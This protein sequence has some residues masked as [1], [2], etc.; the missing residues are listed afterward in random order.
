MA[1]KL[2]A[3]ATDITDEERDKVEL[4]RAELKPFIKVCAGWVRV[5]SPRDQG[6]PELIPRLPPAPR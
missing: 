4:L 6:M 1:E 3:F 2:G 5:R